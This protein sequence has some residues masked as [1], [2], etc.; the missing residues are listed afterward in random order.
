MQAIQP[1]S[2]KISRHIIIVAYDADVITCVCVFLPGGLQ[3]TNEQKDVQ[4][5][6]L[7]FT[8][9]FGNKTHGVVMQCYQPILVRSTIR[10]TYNIMATLC[11]NVQ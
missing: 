2:D 9:V 8:D 5:H 6:F 4:F 10:N 1:Q 3:V 11:S 7:V